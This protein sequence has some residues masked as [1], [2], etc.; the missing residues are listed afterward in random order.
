MVLCFSFALCIL[1]LCF[2]FAFEPRFKFEPDLFPF[3]HIDPHSRSSPGFSVDDAP[4]VYPGLE[5]FGNF[6]IPEFD[7]TNREE[8]SLSVILPV[9]TLSLLSLPAS[10]ELIFSVSKFEEIIITCPES[11]LADVRRI[12]RTSV[13]AVSHTR[14][15]EVSVQTWPSR[16]TSSSAILLAASLVATGCVVLLDGQGLTG[17]DL[18]T[19]ELFLKPPLTSFPLGPRGFRGY[20]G[21]LT[22]LASS[23]VP[24][25]ASY[26]VPPFVVTSA[27]VQEFRGD[28]RTDWG[29]EVFG[30][31]IANSRPEAIGGIM[32]GF[33]GKWC[34]QNQDQVSNGGDDQSTIIQEYEPALDKL[35][36]E[37]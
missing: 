9:D 29:W 11:I 21:N 8:C 35:G 23:D 28:Y 13:G 20:F 16:T 7:L 15:T 5:Q 18:R 1:A 10:L 3:Q 17:T 33:D 24:R 4:P 36:V 12:V 6:T 34:S 31:L 2:T 26:L 32:A 19:L 37:E 27:L 22:C 14:H 25:A 30:R